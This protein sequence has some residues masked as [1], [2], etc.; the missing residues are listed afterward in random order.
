LVTLCWYHH[1]VAVHQEGLQIVRIGQSRVRLKR[2][3]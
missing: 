2:P 1:H 3:R